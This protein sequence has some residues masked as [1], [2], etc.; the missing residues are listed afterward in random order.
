MNAYLIVSICF[1]IVGLLGFVG[2][3]TRLLNDKFYIPFCLSSFIF[4]GLYAIQVT[5]Q[6]VIPLVGFSD[7]LNKVLFYDYGNGLLGLLPLALALLFIGKYILRMDYSDQWSGTTTY[8][9]LSLKYGLIAGLVLAAIPLLIVGSTGQKFSP[10]VD[11]YRYGINCVTN[12]YEEIIC[13]GLLLACCV[14]Y[15]T[16]LWAVVWTSV[17]FG[18]AHGLTEKSVALALGAGLM[19][20]A[21]LRAKSLWAGWTSHQLTDMVVDTFLP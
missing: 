19:A 12:L 5:R 1:L 16:R 7:K 9:L 14:K 4:A 11:V 17:V 18:L 15:W 20:W 2:S 8:T 21:V 10:K 6:F 3:K 13:R